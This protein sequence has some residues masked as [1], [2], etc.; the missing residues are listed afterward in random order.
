MIGELGVQFSEKIGVFLFCTALRW[1]ERPPSLLFGGD[2]G[3]VSPE[4][5]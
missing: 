4:L 5:K 2:W 3:L 1:L